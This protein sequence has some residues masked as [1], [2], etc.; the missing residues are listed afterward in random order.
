M[1]IVC[2]NFDPQCTMLATGSMDS[3][4]KVRVT[5]MCLLSQEFNVH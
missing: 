4:A 5:C 2:V 1:E 3:T